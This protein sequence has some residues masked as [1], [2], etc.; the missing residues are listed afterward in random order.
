MSSVEKL[1]RKHT[2][3]DGGQTQKIGGDGYAIPLIIRF[4]L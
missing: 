2:G 1:H 4:F 3:M